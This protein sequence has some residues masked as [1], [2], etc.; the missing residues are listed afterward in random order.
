M[1]NGS[2]GQE[3]FGKVVGGKR[4]WDPVGSYIQRKTQDDARNRDKG[5]AISLNFVH[6]LRFTS[7]LK[8]TRRAR[9]GSDCYQDLKGYNLGNNLRL[10]ISTHLSKIDTTNRFY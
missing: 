7:T 5:L 8:D 1:N 9:C 3:Y 10:N 6:C 2:N 4:F